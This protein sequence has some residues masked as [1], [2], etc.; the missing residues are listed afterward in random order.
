MQ[1]EKSET[2]R[3]VL[4]S[5]RGSSCR[6]RALSQWRRERRDRGRGRQTERDTH[7]HRDREEENEKEKSQFPLVVVIEA[8]ERTKEEEN[9]LRF[10][11]SL[12][13]SNDSIPIRLLTE[14]IIYR[15]Q[16]ERNEIEIQRPDGKLQSRCGSVSFVAWNF[17]R[18]RIAQQWRLGLSMNDTRTLILLLILDGGSRHQTIVICENESKRVRTQNVDDASR[19]F[20]FSMHERLILFIVL[21][22]FSNNHAFIECNISLLKLQWIY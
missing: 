13:F 10:F 16:R 2:C 4:V 12:F 15:Y 1:N 20:S 11:S 6:V 14:K 8:Q 17:I 21:F 9:Q 22:Q 3:H 7:T 5:E 19:V 18:T